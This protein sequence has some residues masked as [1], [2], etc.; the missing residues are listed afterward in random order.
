MATYEEVRGLFNDSALKNKVATAVIIAAQGI[1]EN[2]AATSAQKSWADKAFSNPEAEARRIYMSVLAANKD[3]AVAGIT[4]AT[5]AA[6]QTNVD[7]AIAMFVDAD[8]G[9]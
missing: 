1:L 5:D 8:A 6:I 2:G 3:T 7:A 4:G 9:V